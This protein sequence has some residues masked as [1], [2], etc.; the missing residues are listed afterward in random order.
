MIVVRGGSMFCY[1]ANWKTYFS[2]AQEIA[3][4]R[5]YKEGFLSLAQNK[6]LILCPSFLSLPEMGSLAAGTSLKLGAQNVSF[7]G[8]GA[9]TGE[10]SAQSL[11]ETGCSAAIIGHS[12]ARVREVKNDTILFKKIEKTLSA[13]LLPVYCVGETF[14]QYHNGE[15]SAVIERQ[16]ELLYGLKKEI[17]LKKKKVEIYIGYEPIFA[18]GVGITASTAHIEKMVHKIKKN[19]SK[20]EID[21]V[22]FSVLYGGSVTSSSIKELKQIPHIDGF[23]IGKSSTDF[24]EFKKI[25]DS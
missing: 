16:L 10:V 18:V 6:N 5:E 9:Y 8:Q 17:G 7:H 19:V 21:F 25:I 11:R 12:E 3:F 1:V 15:S 2:Y 14:D 23:L 22:T 4:F 20:M 24:A 13:G